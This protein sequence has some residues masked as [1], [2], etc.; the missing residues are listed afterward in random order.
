MTDFNFTKDKHALKVQFIILCIL[1]LVTWPVSIYYAHLTM[2]LKDKKFHY[3]MIFLLTLS[4]FSY[5]LC[6]FFANIALSKQK[7]Y[8]ENSSEFK[9]S[10]YWSGVFFCFVIGLISI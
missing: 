10:N 1:N 9:N 6:I 4:S 5:F 3:I 2:K 7:I 8:F